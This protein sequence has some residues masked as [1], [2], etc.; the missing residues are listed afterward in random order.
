MFWLTQPA[1]M[2]K[3]KR[4]TKTAAWWTFTEGKGR[5]GQ[6]MAI[7]Q[8]APPAADENNTPWRHAN[9]PPPPTCNNPCGPLIPATIIG[10]PCGVG[11]GANPDWWRMASSITLLRGG[12]GYAWEAERSNTARHLAEQ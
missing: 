2:E 9:P 7:G 12:R 6:R 11:P 3:W 1:T 10:P 4:R 8:W 5:E